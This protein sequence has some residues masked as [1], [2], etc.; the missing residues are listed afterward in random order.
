MAVRETHA[1]RHKRPPYNHLCTPPA[2]RESG[3]E[4]DLLCINGTQRDAMGQRQSPLS[5]FCTV[6]REKHSPLG[7]QQNLFWWGESPGRLDGCSA[8]SPCGLGAG[9]EGRCIIN[10]ITNL[11]PLSRQ[12]GFPARTDTVSVGKS[13]GIGRFDRQSA[14]GAHRLP[15]A[16]GKS[17]TYGTRRV[18][19]RQTV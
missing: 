4:W 2:E 16:N 18:H 14:F 7:P 10:L 3:T 11:F 8:I 17:K 13:G 6:F 1:P 15:T 5:Y 9:R 19:E 12:G